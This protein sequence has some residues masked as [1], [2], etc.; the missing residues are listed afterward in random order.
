MRSS[1]I[2]S[3]R[4]QEGDESANGDE[5]GRKQEDEYDPPL[6]GTGEG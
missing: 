6:K 4:E 5:E 2:N 1:S 3:S